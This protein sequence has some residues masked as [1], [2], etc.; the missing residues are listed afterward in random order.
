MSI[1]VM[2]HCGR[3]VYATDDV[4][5]QHVQCP[6]CRQAVPV[7]VAVASA[8][9]QPAPPDWWSAGPFRKLLAVVI[10]LGGM[11]MIH[12]CYQDMKN[13]PRETIKFSKELPGVPPPSR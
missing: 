10:G 12:S 7:P 2:C 11:A 4:A 1:E 9:P 8:T 6:H 5:G 3:V 13:K